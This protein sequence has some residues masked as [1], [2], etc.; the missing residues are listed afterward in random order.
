VQDALVVEEHDIVGCERNQNAPR[1]RI[2]FL[3][4]FEIGFVPARGLRGAEVYM[5]PVESRTQTSSIS[6]CAF[7]NEAA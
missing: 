4:E 7:W 6:G 2:R 3:R 5:M 1:R